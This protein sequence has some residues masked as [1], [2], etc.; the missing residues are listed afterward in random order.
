MKHYFL[1]LAAICCSFTA[2]SQFT[3]SGIVYDNNNSTL[4]GASVVIEGTN[5]GVST[6][7][8]GTFKIEVPTN[9][10]TLVVSF[11]G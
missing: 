5:Q 8:E 2:F 4:P 11:L 3:I 1:V 10:A 6:T 7:S 9:S